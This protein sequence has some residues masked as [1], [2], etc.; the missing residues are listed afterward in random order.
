MLLMSVL[1]LTQTVLTIKMS[2]FYCDFGCTM[3]FTVLLLT[4][5]H[6]FVSR[7]LGIHHA[8][9]CDAWRQWGLHWRRGSLGKLRPKQ[10][11]ML[12][13]FHISYQST[14]WYVICFKIFSL[15]LYFI[16]PLHFCCMY[17]CMYSPISFLHNY[18]CMKW[19]NKV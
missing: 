10:S 16:F 13:P 15:F 17:N 19:Y 7:V 4:V 1:F 8:S 11:P 6:Y 9:G 2:G 5:W 14:F 12:G 18:I 3:C